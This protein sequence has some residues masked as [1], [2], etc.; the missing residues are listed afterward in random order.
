MKLKGIPFGSVFNAS[1]ARNFFI[2]DPWWYSRWYQTITG[3]S[4]WEGAT[5][6]AKT[7]THAPREGNMPLKSG[8]VTPV[9]FK[10]RCIYINF[11]SGYAL[12]SVGLSGLG[13]Q[14]L[15]EQ[16]RW[17]LYTKPFVISFMS[18]QKTTEQRLI[19]LCEFA[20]LLATTCR[21]SS[22]R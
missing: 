21:D 20:T 22:H 1:G 17:Q 16:G 3:R 4:M 18:V 9:E 2:E 11:L 14:W 19:E 10:P 15:L 12:N 7:T 6:I 13:A 5:F 8:T